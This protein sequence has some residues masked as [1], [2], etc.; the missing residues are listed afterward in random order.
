M[1][2]TD[3]KT[4]SR[5]RRRRQAQKPIAERL[6]V[7]C[8]AL[9]GIVVIGSALAIGTVHVSAL[10]AIAALALLGA[11]LEGLTLRRVPWPAVVLAALGLFSA[12]QAIPLPAALV[13]RVSPASAEVWSRCLAPFGERALTRFPL[14]I[15]PSASIAEALKWLTY[16]SV[17]VMAMRTRLRRGSAWLA[18]LLF[19]SVTSVSLITLVHGIADLP[20][21]YGLYH[22][23]FGPGR[24]N[25]GPLLNSNNLAGYAILGLFTGGGLLLSG[26][27]PVPRLAL[28]LGVGVIAAALSLSGSR[29]GVLSVLI[30]GVV[31]LLWWLRAKSSRLS[32]R[33]L[34]L[35]MAPL[36]IGVAVA[37][38]LGTANEAGQLASFDVQRKAS[39]W[40]WSLPMIREH[41]LFGVGRGAFETA[42]PKYRGALDYDWAIVVTHAEN[43]VVQWIAEWGVPVGVAALVVIV[44][45]VLREWYRNSGDRLRFMA[46]TGLAALLLQNFS[47]LGLEIPALAIAAVVALA[48]GERAAAVPST[49]EDRKR[50]GRLALVASA[51]AFAVW[52]AVGVWSRSPVDLERREMSTAYRQLSISREDGAVTRTADEL[53]RRRADELAM[54]RAAE[55]TIDSPSGLPTDSPTG[56]ATGADDLKQFHGRLRQAVLRHPGEAFFPLLG[57]L[58]AIRTREGNALSWLARSLELA[59]TNGPV[60][61]VLAELMHLH[62]VTSQAMLHLRLAGKYDRTLAGAVSTRASAWAQSADQLMAAIPDGPYRLDLLLEAC[63]KVP[64]SELRVTCFRRGAAEHPASMRA[65]ME[66]AQSLVRA[67]QAEQPPCKDTLRE[68]CAA[69][70]EVAIRSARRLEPKEW[71]PGYLLSKVLVARGD[72]AGAAQL[73]A[74]TCPMTFEGDDCW[75]EALA[76]A[77]KSGSIDTI[78]KAA[79]ALAARPCDGMESCASIYTSLA[80]DLESGGQLTLANK[81][82]IRAAE[83][84]PSAARWLKVAEVAAQ[85]HLDGVARAALDRANRSFDASP[86]TRARVELLRE[87]VA[88]TSVAPR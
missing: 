83:A 20:E 87:R 85:A 33:G 7:I 11:V 46:M 66:L 71:R 54:R 10:L 2:S 44:G 64:A 78:S 18:V 32:F 25:V 47:D 6:D 48:A 15:D 19:G 35:G 9:L 51:P 17:Y 43:F 55:L 30:A 12:L 52:V 56:L 36:V 23:D 53:A 41:A 84:E 80:R 24:W 75:H 1:D 39:V 67:M 69:E 72:S 65:Q 74:R 73:L 40:L 70:A 62:G 58:V 88:R 50:F 63:A 16:A 79:D 28:M 26:R 22:P 8:E 59:P 42:F 49:S 38:A 77:I 14:S 86:T 37:I 21:L 13:S 60:H 57:A 61:L 76:L 34:A 82:F 5:R 3:L 81:F 31:A 27:A 68:G 45:Y 29:A 4:D